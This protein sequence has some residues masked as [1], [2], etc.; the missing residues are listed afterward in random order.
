MPGVCA[1]TRHGPTIVAAA[2]LVVSEK[3]GTA[4]TDACYLVASTETT[5]LEVAGVLLVKTFVYC[6]MQFRIRRNPCSVLRISIFAKIYYKLVIR[7]G[8][9]MVNGDALELPTNS[10]QVW[11]F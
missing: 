7:G 8:S 9:V 3:V 5:L 1:T 11:K 6:S 4:N 10:G 2:G